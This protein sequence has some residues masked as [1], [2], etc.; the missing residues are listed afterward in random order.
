MKKLYGFLHN[1]AGKEIEATLPQL[2]GV[3]NLL[4]SNQWIVMLVGNFHGLIY[5]AMCRLKWHL[6]ANRWMRI[7]QKQTRK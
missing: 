5:S 4:I 2:K 3:S 1:V 7:L 6:S